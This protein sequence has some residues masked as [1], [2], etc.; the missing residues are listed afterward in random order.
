MT[1]ARRGPLLLRTA[2]SEH[3]GSSETR[4]DQIVTQTSHCGNQARPRREEDQWLDSEFSGL[5]NGCLMYFGDRTD[6]ICWQ[7][8][9]GA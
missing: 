1:Y 6:R 2:L 8:G 9:C 3:S 4:G 5:T 7:I